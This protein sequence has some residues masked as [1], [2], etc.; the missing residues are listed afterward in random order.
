[1]RYASIQPFK[2][3]GSGSPAFAPP[4]DPNFGRFHDDHAL[5]A[6]IALDVKV[7]LIPPCIFH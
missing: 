6:Q 3:A 4:P 5:A 2:M 1:V 7:I